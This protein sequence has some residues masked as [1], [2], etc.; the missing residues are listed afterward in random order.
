MASKTQ[1]TT[2]SARALVSS[3]RPAIASMSSLFVILV[4]VPP[5][6]RQILHESSH[7][8]ASAVNRF[9]AGQTEPVQREQRLFTR[10]RC[11]LLQL[12]RDPPGAFG[13]CRAVEVDAD[14]RAV[15]RAHEVPG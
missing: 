4:P 7:V 13:H 8:G 1:L 2:S 3:P 10:G 9:F 11:R 12:D 14:G 5:V 15:F 6:D